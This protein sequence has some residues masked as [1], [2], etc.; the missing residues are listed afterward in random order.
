[1]ELN[2]KNQSSNSSGKSKS[3]SSTGKPKDRKGRGKGKRVKKYTHAVIGGQKMRQR[4]KPQAK[5][6]QE[7]EP[8]TGEDEDDVEQDYARDEETYEQQ[9]HEE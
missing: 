6:I 8:D 4:Y 7:W 5:E 9:G 1:M 3:S 2:W